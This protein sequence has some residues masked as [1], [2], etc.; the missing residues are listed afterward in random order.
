MFVVLEMTWLT[1]GYDFIMLLLCRRWSNKTWQPLGSIK[2]TI[3]LSGNVASS[4]LCPCTSIQSNFEALAQNTWNDPR[5]MMD[6]AMPNRSAIPTGSG[7]TCWCY[8]SLESCGF[9]RNPN[10]V[11]Y[12]ISLD[13][14]Y[15]R[16]G[17]VWL[18]V[19]CILDCTLEAFLVLCDS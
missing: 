19:I 4:W 10:E 12:L 11:A 7:W 3:C 15:R 1:K 5:A 8:A 16:Y 6:A 2:S 9:V 18:H 13:C 14:I 17:K